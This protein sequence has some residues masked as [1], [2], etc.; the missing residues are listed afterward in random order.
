MLVSIK[1]RGMQHAFGP[2]LQLLCLAGV[3]LARA[4]APATATV[5]LFGFNWSPRLSRAYDV[6]AE[7]D[8]LA[9]AAARG[10]L[11]VH[12]TPCSALR[13]CDP[14]R[15]SHMPRGPCSTCLAALLALC[16]AGATK[17]AC[18]F[19]LGCCGSC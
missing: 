4:C 15:H 2:R 8:A 6:G 19:G 9:G 17:A 1:Q 18:T 5:E 11:V 10:A 13:S 14:L 16:A 7:R 3:L 12:P